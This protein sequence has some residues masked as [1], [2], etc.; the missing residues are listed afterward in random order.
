MF[1]IFIVQFYL[2]RIAGTP[3]DMCWDTNDK[4]L[5]ITFKN[6]GALVVFQT[7][8]VPVVECIPLY[9]LIFFLIT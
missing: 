7:T 8:C 6:N 1:Y 5:A 3:C 9:V 4:R 2:F